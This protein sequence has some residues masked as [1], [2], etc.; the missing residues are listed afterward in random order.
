[1]TTLCPKKVVHV[2]GECKWARVNPPAHI[3]KRDAL[4][5]SYTQSPLI[6]HSAGSTVRKLLFF[7]DSQTWNLLACF[8]FLKYL[9]LE[10]AEKEK[11]EDKT[12]KLFPFWAEKNKQKLWNIWYI[13][14]VTI[15]FARAVG[16]KRA[17]I[18]CTYI[19]GSDSASEYIFLASAQ[20]LAG[21]ER[22]N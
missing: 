20:I 18:I 21:G 6:N 15:L 2:T 16:K 1:M 19:Y 5:Y 12:N 22:L 7:S 8:T 10:H 9:V 3:A 4:S 13:L 11:R 17:Y 14:T